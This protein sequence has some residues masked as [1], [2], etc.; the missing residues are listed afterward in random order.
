MQHSRM[1]RIAA[2][3]L[4]AL[5]YPFW[6]TSGQVP[7]ANTDGTRRAVRE[8][9]RRFRERVERILAGAANPQGFWGVM[10]RDADT[11]ETLYALN[12][13]EH[14]VPASNAKLFTTAMAL[15]KVGPNFRMQTRILATGPIV[16]GRLQGDLVLVGAGDPN[17]SNRVL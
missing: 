2:L 7:I 6:P 13:T 9:L 3:L 4:F 15:A 14:F 17:L 5:V 11:G 16:N 1:P 8:D 12:E 10:V